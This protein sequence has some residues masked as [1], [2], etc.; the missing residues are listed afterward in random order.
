VYLLRFLI[1]WANAPFCLHSLAFALE[2]RG[3]DVVVARTSAQMRVAI[4]EN[5]QPDDV[6]LLTVLEQ[7]EGLVR[8]VSRGL[9]AKAQSALAAEAML[10]AA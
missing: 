10:S 2:D 9:R 1:A 8:L 5:I 7:S 6:V 3:M 4:S